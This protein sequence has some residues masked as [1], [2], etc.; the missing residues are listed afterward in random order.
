MKEFPV[1]LEGWSLNQRV[2]TVAFV[3]QVPA[4]PCLTFHL[5]SSNELF[6]D[7]EKSWQPFNRQQ[8]S[9]SQKVLE[10]TSYCSSS[11]Y[12]ILVPNIIHDYMSQTMM[13]QDKVY[14]H[15][16][17]PDPCSLL[18]EEHLWNKYE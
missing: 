9:S 6:P 10:C 4:G 2:S 17:F 13:W 18:N 7:E 16:P 15:L 12:Q 1:L 14:V 5:L 8:Y 11:D 3:N